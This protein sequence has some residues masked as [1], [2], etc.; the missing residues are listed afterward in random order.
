MADGDVGDR[1]PPFEA[2][3]SCGS[4]VAKRCFLRPG[5]D[6]VMSVEMARLSG[7]WCEGGG[8]GIPL[9]MSLVY[10]RCQKCQF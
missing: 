7:R 1:P 8:V 2:K 4:G 5:K 6:D 9:P 10:C 3:G